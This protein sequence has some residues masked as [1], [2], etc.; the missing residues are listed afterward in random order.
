MAELYK[1]IL[2]KKLDLNL[3]FYSS[4]FC[5]AWRRIIDSFRVKVPFH[6]ILFFILGLLV[7][8]VINYYSKFPW[9]D[10]N[11]SI[12]ANMNY[13]VLLFLGAWSLGEYF[14]FPVMLQKYTLF[15]LRARSYW[16]RPECIMAA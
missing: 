7:I 10:V 1:N 12:T 14:L 8:A 11:S 2:I 5:F 9:D 3:Y 15:T 6:Y 16:H 13:F 4:E